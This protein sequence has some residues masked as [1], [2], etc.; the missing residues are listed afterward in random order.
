MGVMKWLK[1]N[2]NDY[3]KAVKDER[4]MSAFF[5]QNCL[6]PRLMFSPSDALYSIKFIKILVDLRVPKINFLNIF[7]QIIM[8]IIP[9]IHC[10]T[11][12]ES[13]NLGIFFMEW[14]SMID[15]WT[16]K[17]IW[18]KECSDYSGFSQKVG[19][20]DKVVTFDHYN[21]KIVEPIHKKFCHFLRMCL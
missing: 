14:F 19:E 8:G 15:R 9:T 16:D 5:V 4:D 2:L 18:D 12:N 20:P 10:C 6:Y 7:G 13:E 21:T 3:C 1:E 17:A 11:N